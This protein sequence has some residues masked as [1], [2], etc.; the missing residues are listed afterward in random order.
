MHGKPLRPCYVVHTMNGRVCIVNAKRSKCVFA[1][2]RPN[3]VSKTLH[4]DLEHINSSVVKEVF[5]SMVWYSDVHVIR[6]S[7][8]TCLFQ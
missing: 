3:V 1:D 7:N 4:P 6:S 5:R 8:G 2:S